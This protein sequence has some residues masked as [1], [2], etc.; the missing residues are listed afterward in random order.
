MDKKAGL[1][2]LMLSQ[3]MSLPEEKRHLDSDT[4]S[5]RVLSS[6]LVEKSQRIH[7]YCSFGAEVSTKRLMV[8]LLNRGKELFVP[9]VISPGRLH[10]YRL[11]NPDLLKCS[12]WGIPEPSDTWEREKNLNFDLIFT[13]GVAFDVTGNRLGYGGGFY[14]RFL[15]SSSG[16]R[17]GLAYSF[18]LIP[19]VKHEKHDQ[20]VNAVLTE[21]A[22][23]STHVA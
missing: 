15:E 3:L 14:D 4:I 11:E 23:V 9:R 12:R 6:P 18:Q 22:W 16:F 21:E 5:S 17:L 19:E 10:H 20:K 2:S 1:R 7:L 13:P 8:S